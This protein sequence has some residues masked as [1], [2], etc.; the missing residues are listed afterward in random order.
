LCEKS[1]VIYGDRAKRYFQE[2]RI[3]AVPIWKDYFVNLGTGDSILYRIIL[4]DTSDVIYSG[5]AHKRPGEVNIQARVNDICADYLVN[6]LPTLSQ[7]EFSEIDLP[8]SFK[9]QA[10]TNGTTWTD[11]ATIQFINDWSYDYGY[12]PATMGMSF[13]ITGRVDNRM[14]IVWTGLNVSRVTATIWYTDGTSSQVIIPV[15]ISNDF[16][17]DFNSDFSRSVRSAGSGTAVFF[18]SAWDNVDR[19]VI[20]NSTFKVVTEC[21]K[22]ALYYIN[23][24]GGWDCLLIEGN[25]LEDDTLTRHTREVVYDNRDIQNRGVKNYVN[26]ITKGFTLH[27]GWLL[28]DQGEMMHHL[29]N[30]TDVYLYDIANEQMIPVTIPTNTCEYRNFKN[31]GNQLVDYT[32]RVEVAQNR[33]RR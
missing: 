15:A 9:V 31:N 10:S 33:I 8:V 29:I 4:T 19:I 2:K 14:P 30:S 7:A 17:A 16:N 13:P 5:K 1:C 32:I 25:H 21:A 11:K 18:P 24:Y 12:N 23:A 28:H 6:V 3:M 22:Y 26:E 20:G 27:T